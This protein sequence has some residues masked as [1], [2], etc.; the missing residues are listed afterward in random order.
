MNGS[1]TWR[2]FR[3]GSQI[4]NV[5][6]EAPRIWR[7]AVIAAS[8]FLVIVLAREVKVARRCVGCGTA[9]RVSSSYCYV[10]GGA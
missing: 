5:R 1:N 9:R 4:S 8:R 6:G 10:V 2:I 7:D 3:R